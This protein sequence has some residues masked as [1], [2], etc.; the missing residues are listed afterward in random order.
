ME[1]IADLKEEHRGIEIMLGI[2]GGV[3]SKTSKGQLIDSKD[4]DSILEFLSVF[5]DRCHHGKEEDFLFPALEEAGVQR[6]KGPIGVLLRE[7]QEGRQLVAQ[8]R[9]AI[10]SFRSGNAKAAISLENAGRDYISLLTQH[11]QKEDDVLFPMAER[12]LG[13]EKQAELAEAFQQL[14]QNRIGQGRHE[15]FHNQL[16]RLK[17]LYSTY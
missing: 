15:E 3:I 10:K 11:I 7:H 9:E 8:F 17:K 2:M 14:E 6:D 5:V 12:V 1:P 4:F 13:S 16:H